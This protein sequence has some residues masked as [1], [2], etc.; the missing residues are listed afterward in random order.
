MRVVK[1]FVERF[2]NWKSER[3]DNKR[4]LVQYQELVVAETAVLYDATGVM[5]HEDRYVLEMAK[6]E[7]GGLTSKQARTKFAQMLEDPTAVTDVKDGLQRV[8][9]SLD[10]V[11]TFRNKFSRL[12]QLIESEQ[13]R[14]NVSEDERSLLA[15]R[16][17][18]N[19]DKG[20]S[21]S[22]VDMMSMAQRMA[23][24]A[25]RSASAFDANLLQMGELT[26]L[27]AEE[28]KKKGES[29]Q[30]EKG[31]EGEDGQGQSHEDCDDE[32]ASSNAP[33]WMDMDRAISRASR[34]MANYLEDTAEKFKKAW[35]SLL[36]AETDPKT[37]QV[38]EKVACGMDVARARRR[39][40]GYVLGYPK[41]SDLEET[42]VSSVCSVERVL[43]CWCHAVQNCR[44]WLLFSLDRSRRP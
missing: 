27:V 17:L 18:S 13:S 3:T 15:S 29:E 12:K 37:Q 11:V 28:G 39:A 6:A 4:F 22:N 19:H 43:V 42:S 2:P 21:N 35:K 36:Q 32:K 1:A 41:D 38:L 16:V 31:E 40:I 23:K 26:E 24:G 5:M 25:G 33:K 20:F 9:V 8:R 30:K 10:D 14:K 7:R 34:A 44:F